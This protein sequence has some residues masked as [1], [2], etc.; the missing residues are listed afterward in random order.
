MTATR[1][2]GWRPPVP[3]AW[4]LLWVVERWILARPR[5][6]TFFSLAG[7]NEPIS[8]SELLDALNRRPMRHFALSGV[9]GAGGW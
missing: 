8:V 4:R 6:R 9:V 5:N 1:S 2:E 3:V 7:E